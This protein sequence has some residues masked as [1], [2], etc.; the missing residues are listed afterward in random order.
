MSLAAI[1]DCEGPRLSAEEKAFFKDVDPWGFIVFARHCETADN[2]RAHCDELRDCVGRAD[3]PILIDQEGGRVA[4]MR[5]PHF[6]AHPPPATFG[7]LWRQDRDK[8]RKASR[9][10]GY[11]LG[12]LVSDCGVTVN[13]I[14]MADVPQPDADQT[15]IGDRAYAED[16]ETIAVLAREAATGLIEG[17][18]LPVVK[19]LPGHGRAQC[20]SHL[21]LPC[22]S[23]SRQ[24]LNDIDFAPF[25]A[26]ND[27]KMGMT[28]HVLYETYDREHCASLS[29]IVIEEVIRGVIG[30]D[31]LLMSDDLKMKALG[32]PFEARMRDS[33]AAGCDLALCCNF[34]MA[35]KKEALRGAR[36]LEG[37]GA[38]R[39]AAALAELKPVERM[40]TDAQYAALHQLLQPVMGS[41]IL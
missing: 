31:G 32:G 4:R 27:L 40:A 38:A 30:F 14:P 34:S 2:L 19:H 13:C 18:A 33:L 21:A 41:E 5:S 11:L 6:P 7:A 10:N 26:L 1:F 9:L 35:E 37:R 17:G 22:V 23:A 3:A 15:V 28:A 20:D 36:A 25:R 16:P 8:A 24:A 39:A 29:P 12:R